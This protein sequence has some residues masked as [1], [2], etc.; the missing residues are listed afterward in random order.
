MINNK[1]L[2]IIETLIGAGIFSILLYLSALFYG[3]VQR[4]QLL[5][6][7]LWQLTAIIREAQHKSSS[8]KAS[9]DNHLSFGVVF[10]GN[11]YQEFATTT[12]FISR[13]TAF[14]LSTNLPQGIR[15]LNINMPNNCVNNNDCILFNPMTGTP[16][17]IGAVTMLEDS[18]GNSKRI[19]INQEGKVSF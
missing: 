3:R 7:N 9:G 8:G 6:D 1:G 2:S 4:G 19:N 10:T 11:G 14:D 5:T 17:A 12:N 13:D 16:S 15:F 18:S